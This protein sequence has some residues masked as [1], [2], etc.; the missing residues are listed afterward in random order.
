MMFNRNNVKKYVIKDPPY[1]WKDISEE[2]KQEA[3]MKLS[4]GG[5]FETQ[6]YWNMGWQTDEPGADCPNWVARWLLYHQ[7]QIGYQGTEEWK[8]FVT[9]DDQLGIFNET[10]N[11]MTVEHKRRSSFPCQMILLILICVLLKISRN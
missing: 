9:R 10:W 1:A 2:A 7:F 4:F 6:P 3:M 8:K 5:N 11:I